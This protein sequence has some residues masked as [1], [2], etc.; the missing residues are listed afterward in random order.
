MSTLFD[1]QHQKVGKTVPAKQLNRLGNVTKVH[2][3][4]QGDAPDRRTKSQFQS[5]G[6]LLE[7]FAVEDKGGRISRE[8]QDY[9]YRL[10]VDLND[11]DHKSLYMKL[12]KS[13][14]RR[15]LEQARTFVL[16]ANATSKARL[17]MW[18]LSQL[19]KEAKEKQQQRQRTQ[20]GKEQ[21]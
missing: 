21:G 16:D 9:A 8:F 6:S 7:R 4:M 14:E 3:V 5:L 15:M 11:L 18:K 19:R 13:V 2:A 12:A 10:A 17:F 1:D 20:E